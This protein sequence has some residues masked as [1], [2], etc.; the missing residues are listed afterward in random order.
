[1]LESE[2]LSLIAAISLV[3]TM[4]LGAAYVFF[5]PPRKPVAKR[6]LPESAKEVSA[7]LLPPALEAAA[8]K[9]GVEVRATLF[10]RDLEEL[11]AQTWRTCPR[12]WPPLPRPRPT[13]A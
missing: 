11:Y 10:S 9:H 4:A 2:T 5:G 7:K 13:R 6:A 12:S 3:P 1:M 8:K